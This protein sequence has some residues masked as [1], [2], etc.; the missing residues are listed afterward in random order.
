MLFSGKYLMLALCCFVFHT[1]S[2]QETG[3]R[4]LTNVKPGSKI[5]LIMDFSEAIIMGKTE[6]EFADYE[7]DWYKDKPSIINKFEK[8]ITSRL[9]GVLKVGNYPEAAYTLRV[10]V[11][12]I[13]DMGNLFCD[14][15]VV[16]ASGNE[17]FGVTKINGGKEPLFLPGS[18]LAKMKVWALIVGRSLG[19]AIKK[20][21]LGE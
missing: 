2:A 14:A 12:V 16:D 8:G 18:K 20:E 7:K 10:K 6:E 3:E 4:P 5:N 21:Y 19:G 1:I 15:A 9:S 13:T 11:K 17:L